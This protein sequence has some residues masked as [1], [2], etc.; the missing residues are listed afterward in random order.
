MLKEFNLP[1]D[2]TDFNVIKKKYRKL[3]KLYHPDMANGD[4]GK[5]KKIQEDYDILKI[6]MNQAS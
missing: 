4:A 5:F 3:V 1:I 6:Y 2:T